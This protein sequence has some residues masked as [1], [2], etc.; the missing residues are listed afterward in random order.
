MTPGLY[1]LVDGG[2]NSKGVLEQKLLRFICCI[3]LTGCW[4]LAAGRTAGFSGTLVDVTV[5][6]EFSGA[7]KGRNPN[8]SGLGR[9]IIN[10]KTKDARI[11]LETGLYTTDVDY[12][13]LQSITQER[14]LDEF[15]STAT[16]A[17]T[18]FTA[19]RRNV[20]ILAASAGVQH[21][22]FLLSEEEEQ[23][24]LRKQK[25]NTQRLRVPRRPAWMK[26]MTSAQLD[27]Q[28][29]DAFLEWR[30][31]LAEL[32]DR[33][34]FLLT[35]F[36]RNIEVWRQ[37]WRVLE[38]SHLVVQI[39]DARNPLRFR[40]ED[41]EAYVQDVEG[42][43]G[44]QGT[45]KGKRRSLLLIN[46]A[47]L[48]T[49]G[50]RYV[51]LDHARVQR[52][53]KYQRKL[54][55]DYFDSQ[56]VKYAFFSAA[57]A[58]ALQEARK[59]A[60]DTEAR[61]EEQQARSSEPNEGEDTPLSQPATAGDEALG[62]QESE[63]S[64]TSEDS[65]DEDELPEEDSDDDSEDGAFLPIEDDQDA[66]DPRTRV[67]SVL[68]LEDLFVKSA[69]DLACKHCIFSARVHLNNIRTAFTDSSGQ[70]PTRLVIGLVGYPN[71][72]KSSTINA[73]L[74]EKKVSV[75]STPGK[76][77]HFQTIHLSP[78]LVLCDCP[79]LVF[80]QFATT[81]A[82]LVCDGVLPIDQMREYT[83]PTALIVKRI[84]REVLE[85]IYGLSIRVKGSE[86]GGNGLITGTDFLI[87]YAIARGFTRAGQG[88]PDEAR[89]A[90]YILKDYVNAKLLY[91]HPPPGVTEGD[92]NEQTRKMALQRAMGKKRAPTTR[93]TKKADTFIAPIPTDGLTSSAGQSNKS[94][95]VD[96]DFF[97]NNS[98]LSARPFV[99]GARGQGKEFSRTQL[100]PHQNM[101]ADDGT[102]LTGRRARIVAVMAAGG[103]AAPGKKQH[104]KMKRVKQRSGK[105]YD[106]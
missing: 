14:D 26:A 66:Q 92:F 30:R 27:R 32:Q 59:E 88:N 22:P 71:V 53:N 77:K 61:L 73:L 5:S 3:L 21:N 49:S 90:R 105:G 68:E 17:G 7:P 102:V 20:K 82:D 38:R 6:W 78:S 89:A 45:G 34:Q 54:W 106:D 86:D 79:G 29:K 95:K 98:S 47:D 60:A 75:S 81:K 93:V 91:C 56:G 69:P 50:Q 12:T 41:L 62:P 10:R 87:A 23:S 35:P 70:S 28:E 1:E 31:G 44:E 83:A 16:L 48:L 67:L 46:K 19:E 64:D 104:K 63:D 96:Q 94:R 43:E 84:P 37:L 8:P 76:T 103:E 74:G 18:D 80:P 25:E 9:A 72:G 36:E 85:A 58:A 11:A 2:S 101:V 40:C 100:Y 65:P 51:H 24:T 99:Q 13:R 55:A 52:S 97:A 4:S 33:D 39:V 15:L 57:N 42:A